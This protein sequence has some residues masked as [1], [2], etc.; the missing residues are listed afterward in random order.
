VNL[1]KAHLPAYIFGESAENMGSGGVFYGCSFEI[2]QDHSHRGVPGGV[3]VGGL[4][5]RSQPLKAA[6]AGGCDICTGGR[7]TV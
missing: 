1:K 7:G 3:P 6:E 4:L 5:V 2:G